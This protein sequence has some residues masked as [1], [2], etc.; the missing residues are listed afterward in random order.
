MINLDSGP[1]PFTEHSLALNP[2]LGGRDI[3]SAFKGGDYQLLR[4]ANK[5]QT[6]FDEPLLCAMDVDKRLGGLQAVQT[7]SRLK[8]HG[9]ASG[10]GLRLSAP[11]TGNA[12]RGLA[13]APGALRRV[14]QRPCP[15]CTRT[16]RACSTSGQSTS[17]ASRPS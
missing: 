15:P 9:A 14:A 1:D 13:P 16:W 2:K 4:V 5:F 17:A 6:G 8:R 11:Q 3:R 10:A 12:R 7:L